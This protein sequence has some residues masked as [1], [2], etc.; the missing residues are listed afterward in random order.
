MG[1]I[2]AFNSLF[3]DSANTV[4]KTVGVLDELPELALDMPD[5]EL[6]ALSA[7]WEKRYQPYETEIK[8]R[9]EK[10][11][12][13]W[14]GKH[15]SN[16]FNDK[17]IVDNLIFEA[18]E[19][20]L[21]LAT[22]KNPEPFVR[23]N[24]SEQSQVLAKTV[25][26]MLVFH[27]DRLRMKLRLKMVA[28]DWAIKLIGVKKMAWD[29]VA[30]DFTSEV[31]KPESMIFDVDGSI[32][33]DMEY[34]GKYLGQRMSDT[35][36]DLIAR[37]PEK[38]KFIKDKVEGKL[39]TMVHYI[40]WWACNPANYMFWQCEKEILG[41]AKN[42]HWNYETERN[43]VD[44]YG[45]ETPVKVP[46]KNHFNTPKAP[47]IFL[48]G[49]YNTGDSPHDETS[50]IEQSIP[51]QDLINK[52]QMQIE[53]NVDSMNP[54]LIISL[55]GAGMTEAQATDA[56][57]AYRKGG[58]VCIPTGSPTDAIYQ[59]VPSGLPGDVFQQLADT[60]EELRNSFGVRGSSPSGT[61]AEQTATGKTIVREQ[62]SDRIGGGLT[63]YLE[64]FADA[65]FN[66][67]LQMMYVYYDEAHTGAVVGPEKAM[68]Y[69]TLSSQDLNQKLMVSVKEGSLIPDSDADKAQE[70]KDLLVQGN[71]D[72]ITAFDRMGYSNP[73][74]TAER[75]F[76]WKSDP[77]L[78]FPE[79]DA[80]IK[81][82]EQEQLM[83]Q[84]V[85]RQ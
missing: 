68:E 1:L 55:S 43:E 71:I 60:R 9:Q 37:F 67:F 39:G 56:T 26:N 59:P 69:L 74:E 62:D 30:N 45:N 6:L 12:S 78:L 38:E 77:G 81:A 8:K 76:L 42:M 53:A 19:T 10:N 49:V 21:P 11:K 40:E 29:E 18:I 46:G 64:Q 48:G 47:F 14:K 66:W 24:E 72:P 25:Q 79:L 3:D 84:Q 83:N 20:F 82:R 23:G 15:E 35:A 13:Y 54:G 70:S 22:K 27:A 31:I 50:L 52:R 65:E 58:T 2:G 7:Q 33:C 51:M 57:E 80:Q 17:G 34:T 16:K 32:N 28:R 61:V 41:K 73:R 75:T 36:S 44:E 63:E 5:E 4:K 85:I